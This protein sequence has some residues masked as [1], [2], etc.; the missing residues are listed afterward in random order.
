MMI[1]FFKIKICYIKLHLTVENSCY[2][3]ER[4]K[5]NIIAILNLLMGFI[6]GKE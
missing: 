6:K 4:I 2:E 5:K 1:R 3:K